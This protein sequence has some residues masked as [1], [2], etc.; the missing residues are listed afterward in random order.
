MKRSRRD[1]VIDLEVIAQT[2][3]SITVSWTAPG[4][5]GATGTAGTYDL[6]Y[7]TRHHQRWQTGM[8]RYSVTTNRP[9]RTAGQRDTCVMTGLNPETTYYFA[10]K[11]A[12]EVPNWSGL[13]NIAVGATSTETTPAPGTV[14]NLGAGSPGET[15]VVLNWTAPGDDG[16]SGHRRPIR[17]RY[18]TS[19]IT[20]ANFTSAT[21]I[22]G[23]PSPKAAGSAESFTVT[24][25]NSGTQ[26]WFA[27]RTAD[28]VPNWSGVSN[29]PTA[30]T[31][32]DA[33]APAAVT[34][35]AAVLPTLNSLTLVWPAPGDDGM[36]GQGHHL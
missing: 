19:Q 27:I 32:D 1:D 14:A 24:G 3:T 15:S 25:L 13:S 12:D 8:P 18:A 22:A 16:F 5:D 2:P 20:A 33:T 4:D 36:V 9:P 6:R 28:E 10:L 34:Q 17:L 23:E 21:Q 30:T 7:A 29:S 31:L 11:T 35:L 26:Y